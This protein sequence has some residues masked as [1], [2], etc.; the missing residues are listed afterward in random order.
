[1]HLQRFLSLTRLIVLK[2][3]RLLTIPTCGPCLSDTIPYLRIILLSKHHHCHRHQHL[4]RIRLQN[5][6]TYLVEEEHEFYW[7]QFGCLFRYL[8]KIQPMNILLDYRNFQCLRLPCQGIHH[9]LCLL[10]RQLVYQTLF[11]NLFE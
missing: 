3:A 10:H 11:L 7:P 9:H 4:L 6:T 8:G 2:L 5:H 1:M